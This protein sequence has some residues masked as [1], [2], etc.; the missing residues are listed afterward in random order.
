M[1]KS[2]IRHD[3]K[4]KDFAGTLQRVLHKLNVPV[5]LGKLLDGDNVSNLINERSQNFYY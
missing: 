1:R 2:V 3:P 4:A 5:A